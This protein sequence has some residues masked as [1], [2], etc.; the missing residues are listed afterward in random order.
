MLQR[1]CH[2]NSF[3]VPYFPPRIKRKMS[4]CEDYDESLWENYA[5]DA[6]GY[7]PREEEEDEEFI[8]P[9]LEEEAD[10]AEED[11]EEASSSAAAALKSGKG[12]DVMYEGAVV[13]EMKRG[14]YNKDAPIATLDFASLYP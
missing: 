2:A 3:L 8:V 6:E 13:M 1:Y 4:A 14:F 10:S 7:V 5:A 12:K 11:E 9:A